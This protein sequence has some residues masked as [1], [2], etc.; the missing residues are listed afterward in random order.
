MEAIAENYPEISL[1]YIGNPDTSWKV[2]MSN[3][4]VPGDDYVLEAYPWYADTMSDSNGFSISSPYYDTQ[5]KVYN[6]TFSKTLYGKGLERTSGVIFTYSIFTSKY[7]PA[8]KAY[9][10]V[11]ISSYVT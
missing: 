8:A 6:L 10:F 5:Q 11:I 4:W 2:I 9:F 7:C 3:G 1:V